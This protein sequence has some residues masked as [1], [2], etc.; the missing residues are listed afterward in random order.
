MTKADI[1][2]AL[3]REDHDVLKRIA[4]HR[5]RLVLRWLTGRLYSADESEKWKAIR[6]LGALVEDERS[7]DDAQALEMLR[8]FAW[9]LNDESGAV[10]YGIPEAMGEVLAVRPELQASFLPILCSL[11]VEDDMLQTGPIER[12]ALWA[13]GRVGLAVG[14]CSPQAI[15]AV[16]RMA[17]AHP[18][19][20]TREVAARSLERIT[21]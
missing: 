20:E 14:A 2:L 12:G 3:E 6:A 21:G 18:D 9:A 1:E 13:V 7:I 19:P 10:P 15:E 8:R 5:P 17:A 4:R 11:L 16:R